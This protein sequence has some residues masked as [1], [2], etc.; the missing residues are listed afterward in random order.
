MAL[1]FASRS[2]FASERGGA[3][4]VLVPGLPL[5]KRGTAGEAPL[6]VYAGQPA[7]FP[8]VSFQIAT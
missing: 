5:D 8:Y 6:P 1:P 4:L 7:A 2:I 3:S